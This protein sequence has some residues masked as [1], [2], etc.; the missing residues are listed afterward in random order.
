MVAAVVVVATV[1]VAAAEAVAVVVLAAVGDKVLKGV[2]SALDRRRK[3]MQYTLRS[4]RH[5]G[6]ALYVAKTALMTVTVALAISCSALAA[7]G[8]MLQIKDAPL[9]EVVM[10]L[11]QQSGA[12]IVIADDSKLEK[13]VTA[14]LNDIPL[15]SA[16]NHIVKSAGVS[17]RKMEDGTYIIGGTDVETPSTLSS[18][19]LAKSLP[20]VEPV[21]VTA[22]KEKIITSIKLIHS[23]PSELLHVLLESAGMDAIVNAGNAYP[24]LDKKLSLIQITEPTKP[25]KKT[26]AK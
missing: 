16:L 19:D 15:E 21:E 17:Y 26:N 6:T 22:P 13:K 8:I 10:L 12:N 23:R 1:L 24:T 9:K 20:S 5:F 11:T 25:K 14:S 3:L 4:W 18:I 7:N 2:F